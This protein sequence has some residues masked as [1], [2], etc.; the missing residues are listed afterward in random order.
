[1]S[2]P[3]QKLLVVA[4]HPDDEILG[5]GG[6]IAKLAKQGY[7]VTVLTVS[8][9]LPPLYPQEAYERT[10]KEAKAAHARVGVHT[11]IFLGVPAT[12]LGN[13]PVAELNGKI[14][15]VVRDVGPSIVLCPYPDRHVDHRYVF[16]STMVATR[17]VGHG[18]GIR[19]VAAYE[20]LSETHWNAPHIEPN[21]TPNWVVDITDF[22]DTKLAALRCYESQISPFP[23]PRSVEAVQ[24]LAVFRGTQAGFAQGE[25]LHIVRM[26][27]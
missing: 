4:P 9:H 19:V 20:T 26:V 11:S 5:V 27:S 15:S 25:A 23:G 24:A 7:E 13:E 14:V 3:H 12:M 22:I 10:L 6:T 16:E 21:F 17:P 18:R 1:M 2:E 8:G